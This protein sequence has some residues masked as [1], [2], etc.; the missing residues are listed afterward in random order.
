MDVSSLCGESVFFPRDRRT[1]ARRVV[2]TGF[3]CHDETRN[4]LHANHRSPLTAHCSP[5]TAHHSPL[6]A[7]R[8]PLTAHRSPLTAHCS[9]LT[10]HHSPL[11]THHSPL[12]THH[13]PLTAH[14]SPLTTHHSPL[15]AHYSLLTAHCSLGTSFLHHEMVRQRP[16]A[17]AVDKHLRQQIAFQRPPHPERHHISLQSVIHPQRLPRICP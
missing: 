11:T 15:T 2:Q 13:S 7:H 1:P 4:Q 12:T 5:L 16:V 3:Q 10:T 17:L 14:R 8:S 9:P 6:T